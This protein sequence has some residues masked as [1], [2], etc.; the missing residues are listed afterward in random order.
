MNVEEGHRYQEAKNGRWKFEKAENYLDCKLMEISGW[1][2]ETKPTSRRRRF[3]E[4]GPM[5]VDEAECGDSP[6]FLL[7]R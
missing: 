4:F 5:S 7:S 6:P 3:P 2:F 1:R